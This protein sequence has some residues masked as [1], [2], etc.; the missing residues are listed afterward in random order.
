MNNAK[1]A[2]LMKN[3]LLSRKFNRGT[4]KYII[5]VIYEFLYSREN[6]DSLNLSMTSPTCQRHT[7]H[8]TITS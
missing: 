7:S 1:K 5:I 6:N 2:E 8:V 3:L 4:Y